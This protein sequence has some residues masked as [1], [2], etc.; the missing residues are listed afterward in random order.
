MSGAVS[1]ILLTI[2]I[3]SQ[4]QSEAGPEPSQINRFLPDFWALAAVARGSARQDVCSGAS[5]RLIVAPACADKVVIQPKAA[6]AL[7]DRN[8]PQA[9]IRFVTSPYASHQRV[10][11]DQCELVYVCPTQAGRQAAKRP[12][13]SARAAARAALWLVRLESDRS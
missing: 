2:D 4:G 8:C 11:S 12:R 1:S 13:H 3:K 10:L 9:R 5:S 6:G 7:G